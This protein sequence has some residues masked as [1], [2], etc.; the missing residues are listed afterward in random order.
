MLKKRSFLF[1]LSCCLAAGLWSQNPKY[2]F[3]FIG[4]GMGMGSV[5]AT[6]MYLKQVYNPDSTLLMMQF[7]V[8]GFSTTYC[9]NRWETDSPAAGTAIANGVKTQYG[10]LGIGPDEKP[11]TSF[12]QVMKQRGRGVGIL[13]TN[14]PDDA[15]PAAFYASTDS[16]SKRYAINRDAA[17]SGFDFFGGARLR[18]DKAKDAEPKPALEMMR[19]QGYAIAEGMDEFGNIKNEEK[20]LLLSKDTINT[21][22]MGIVIDNEPGALRLPEMTRVCLDHL[23]K[24]YLKKGFCMLVEGGEMDHTNHSKDAV[25][26]IHEVLE[27]DR[28]L[29]VAYDFYRR[30]PKETLILV[31]ADHETGGLTVGTHSSAYKADLSYGQYQR[32]SQIKFSKTLTKM[33]LNGKEISWPEMKQM[34]QDKLGFWDGIPISLTE[35]G[36]LMAAYEKA[37]VKKE[38]KTTQTLYNSFDEFTREAFSIIADK[39]AMG[40]TT[41]SH[42]GNPVPFFAI[43]AG[44]DKYTGV[45]DNSEIVNILYKMMGLKNPNL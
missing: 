27:F 45:I 10:Y 40:W 43:G 20:I 21:N 26:T 2:I 6:D 29:R 17:H 34:L 33:M 5:Q 8:A 30:Y 38:G 1:A 31:T 24:R 15:T 16:R 36:R 42:T 18:G 23:K 11:L 19:E 12:F 7:P 25:A 3:I 32:V 39:M 28:S 14:S 44:A 41:W 9:T 35:E 4:D 37:F 22:V 13:T